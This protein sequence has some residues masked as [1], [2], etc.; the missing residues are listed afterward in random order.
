VQGVLVA[1]EAQDGDGDWEQIATQRT[2]T[3]I[4]PGFDPVT[5]VLIFNDVPSAAAYRVRVDPENR[6]EELYEGNNAGILKRKGR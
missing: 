4:T 6:I 3:L 1:L 2:G 5:E